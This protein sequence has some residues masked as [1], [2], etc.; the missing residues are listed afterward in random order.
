MYNPYPLLSLF[1]L[2]FSTGLLASDC[3]CVITKDAHGVTYGSGCRD[4]TDICSLTV[5]EGV[6]IVDLSAFTDLRDVTVTV[7]SGAHPEF[8]VTTLVNAGTVID[9]DVLGEVA[10]LDASIRI[11]EDG[12][13]LQ[14][15]DDDGELA[16]LSGQLLDLGLC[17]DIDL[18]F[19]LFGGLI[20]LD[21]NDANVLACT[22]VKIVNDKAMPV[23]LT[24][25][26]ATPAP[27]GGVALRWRTATESDNAYFR[28]LHG[29]DGVHFLEVARLNGRGSTDRAADYAY[30]HADPSAGVNYYRLEQVDLDGTVHHLGI[31][32]VAREETDAVTPAPN[33]V[34]AGGILRLYGSDGTWN[35]V[36]LFDGAGRLRASLPVPS[37]GRLRL[38]ADLAPGMYVLRCGKAVHRLVVTR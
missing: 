18:G 35:T 4:K 16:L 28:L 7:L 19:S 25:W 12:K 11:V 3:D 24:D 22:F 27:G 8:L 17:L 20:N 13:L 10:Q 31:R 26:S 29:T 9:L 32:T 34:A 14:V 30:R 6:G 33:P 36:S 15:V 2:L 23:T 21:L 1:F 37:D 38:P 5:G